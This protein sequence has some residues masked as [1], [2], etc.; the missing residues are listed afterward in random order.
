MKKTK[1]R[2]LSVLTSL[3]LALSIFSGVLPNGTLTAHADDLEG[4]EIC[5]LCQ[6][7]YEES[8]LC[9]ECGCC[10]ECIASLEELHCDVCGTCCTVWDAGDPDACAATGTIYCG[11]C[12]KDEGLHC[13]DCGKCFCNDQD[14]LCQECGLCND[15][16]EEDEDGNKFI[17]GDCNLCSGCAAH[18]PECGDCQYDRCPAEGKHCLNECE[19]CPNCEEVC[20]YD[21]DAEP[22][23]YCGLCESCCEENQCPDCGMCCEDP[24]YNSH[25]C[26]NCDS[27][28]ETVGE[29]CDN[30]G[31]CKDCC[32]VEAED[33]GCSCGELCY[34]EVDDE[35]IC[36]N[37]GV[38]FGEVDKCD[39]CGL[40]EECCA[41]VSRN[42]GCDCRTPVCVKSDEWDEHFKAYHAGYIDGHTATPANTWSFNASYHFKECK[43]CDESAHY[44]SKAAHTLDKNGNCTV[45]GYSKDMPITITTQ[46]KDAVADVTDKN[47]KADS[48]WS[49]SNNLVKFT[50]TAQGQNLTYRWYKSY[51]SGSDSEFESLRKAKKYLTDNNLGQKGTA[52]SMLR[53]GI[54]PDDC[55]KTIYVRC[56][57]SDGKNTKWTNAAKLTVKHCYTIFTEDL[58]PTAS[59]HYMTCHGMDCEDTELMPHEYDNWVWENAAHTYRSQTCTVCKYADE[60]YIHN[61]AEQM[62]PFFNGTGY[63]QDDNHFGEEFNPGTDPEN[64]DY[65]LSDKY[66]GYTNYKGECTDK[67]G[68]VWK[69]DWNSHTGWCYCDGCFKKPVKVR[70]PHNFGPWEGADNPPM[71]SG[72]TAAIQ[73]RCADC[74]YI[75]NAT[76]GKGHVIEWSMNYHPVEYYDCTGPNTLV[77]NGET[78]YFTPT[79]VENKVQTGWEIVWYSLDQKTFDSYYK[80]TQTI[81]DPNVRSWVV[82]STVYGAGK[83]EIHQ[84]FT[85]CKHPRTISNLRFKVNAVDATC[86]K[87][88]YSGDTICKACGKVLDYGKVLP[89]TGHGKALGV[90]YLLP[91]NTTTGKPI[92][93]N[94][95]GDV[96][97]TT[98]SGKEKVIARCYHAPDCVN[99]VDGNAADT[100]CEKCGLL[101]ERGKRI[102][103]ESLHTIGSS[104]MRHYGAMACT[105]ANH[106]ITEYYK[107]RNCLENIYF[108]VNTSG[109]NFDELQKYHKN[110]KVIN[111]STAT[112]TTAGNSGDY[113]CPDCDTIVRKGESEKPAGHKWN[114][115]VVTSAATCKASGRKTVT[116]TVC[117]ATKTDVIPQK[118]HTFA[119]PTYTWTAD[120]K[121]CTATGK[122][123]TCGDTITE[124]GKIT[125]KVKTAATATAMGVTTY[126]ATFDDKSFTTQTKDVTDIPKLVTRKPGDVNG[127]GEVNIKDVTLLKQY[128]AKWKVNINK[129]NADVTGDG[130][131]NIKD[132]TLLKQ[133]LAKWK[134]TLK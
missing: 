30:C 91:T 67:Y 52:T 133:Y 22:C 124:Q 71:K 132:L 83:I 77:K 110:L 49:Y 129:S 28:L 51:D 126:T 2:L 68:N 20:F 6:E 15:C 78:V 82:N 14:M 1:K 87:D 93:K 113:Y 101:V 19:L 104:N 5:M 79:K 127:D 81:N 53:L 59:G 117:K 76:D 10:D 105:D 106:P 97:T 111:K 62:R 61:H 96:V 112:C 64:W 58:N 35:H 69:A 23:E 21:S 123:S 125:S 17:C 119:K 45:C 7:L 41:E 102:P 108:D 3:V 65:N 40:C 18:C 100:I 120:G 50:V 134:V 57:I 122:C 72:D 24:D 89:K 31:L 33:L 74:G 121:K 92:E 32:L 55:G 95:N 66:I 88:G 11:D 94:S 84:T 13:K 90:N 42:E 80:L 130:E 25:F 115:G 34:L 109:M 99:H 98:N 128:L 9:D 12:L 70:E 26:A 47:A 39:D 38:C 46:P 4:K 27:C 75:Q 37:C 73:R 107:C 63:Y 60:V 118:T 56:L 103:W 85:E 44:T 116:C 43:Y 16:C 36:A 54:E 8:D 86:T 29:V 48:E 131:V 114:S